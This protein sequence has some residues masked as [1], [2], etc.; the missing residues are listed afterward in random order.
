[1]VKHLAIPMSRQIFERSSFLNSSPLSVKISPAPYFKK[2]WCMIALATVVANLSRNGMSIIYLVNTHTAVKMYE[3]PLDEVGNGPAKSHAHL[4]TP[5]FLG[6][7]PPPAVLVTR[8]TVS[9]IYISVHPPSEPVC[10][11]SHMSPC[12]HYSQTPP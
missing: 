12:L 2:T 4:L 11:S 8:H 1:M 3:C 10:S 7:N 5:S 9:A 6:G